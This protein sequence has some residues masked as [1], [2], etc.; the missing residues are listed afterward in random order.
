M[1]ASKQESGSA[2]SPPWEGQDKAL[3]STP[4][5]R[6]PAPCGLADKLLRRAKQRTALWQGTILAQRDQTHTPSLMGRR[7]MLS[8]SSSSWDRKT[9]RRLRETLA[10]TG[11]NHKVQLF[12]KAFLQ[13]RPEANMWWF[14]LGAEGSMCP[15]ISEGSEFLQPVRASE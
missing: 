15:P 4:L 7:S 8:G 14:P 3:E 5:C 13:N 12:L 6:E 2:I 1:A 9:L 11:S 10:Y